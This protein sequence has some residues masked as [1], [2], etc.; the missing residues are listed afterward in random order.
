M[1]YFNISKSIVAFVLAVATFSACDKAPSPTPL[2][3]KG[4]TLVKL[5]DGG[6][7]AAP[8]EKALAIDFIS[9]PQRISLVDLRRD[10]P[11][12]ISLN[13]PMKVV[14]TEDPGLV[15]AVSASILPLPTT[16]YTFAPGTQKLGSTY[17]LNLGAGE[18]AKGIDI[19]V[20]A[21]QLNPS[22]TYGFG[23]KISS[24]DADGKILKEQKAIV[25][26]IGAKNIYDGVYEITGTYSD[27]SAAGATF[28]NAYPLKYALVTTGATTCDVVDVKYQQYPAYIFTTPT[29]LSF[30]GSYG[31]VIGFE[32]TSNAIS[33]FYN[34]YGDP[35]KAATGAGTP[36]AGSGAPNYISANTRRAVL[37][38]S[39]SNKFLVATHDIIVKHWMLQPSV[40]GSAT[41]PRC[42]F[43][44]YWKYLGPR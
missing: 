16:A 39:G 42:F 33:T 36:S 20:V 12:S 44:E 23:F 3:D 30:Y 7:D 26:T 2:G 13:T 27:V 29:G 35:T 1:K 8:G 41:A 15:A 11:S 14:V 9:T 43:N 22:N 31:L 19:D 24:V 4:Q 40:M 10:V 5:I 28:T 32:P 6:T 21:T 38:P 17:T 34:Y 18:F 25:V 37:D